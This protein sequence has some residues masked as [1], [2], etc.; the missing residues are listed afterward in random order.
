MLAD[1]GTDLVNCGSSEAAGVMRHCV[2][3]FRPAVQEAEAFRVEHSIIGP[4]CR[5]FK[6]KTLGFSRETQNKTAAY[7]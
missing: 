3:D 6:P 7:R 1:R 5:L 2:A 4:V